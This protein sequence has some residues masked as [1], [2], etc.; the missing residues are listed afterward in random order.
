[1]DQGSRDEPCAGNILPPESFPPVAAEKDGKQT[2]PSRVMHEPGVPYCII[3]G[4]AGLFVDPFY[5]RR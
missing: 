4:R 5:P 2:H 3:C 1:M